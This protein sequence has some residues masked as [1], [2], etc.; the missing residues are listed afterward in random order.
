[1]PPSNQGLNM[2]L[3]PKDRLTPLTALRLVGRSATADFLMKNPLPKCP[4]REN[5]DKK[6]FHQGVVLP[7]PRKALLKI[8][9]RRG[10]RAGGEAEKGGGPRPHLHPTQPAARALPVLLREGEG[11][12]AGAQICLNPV[13]TGGGTT[14]P[15]DRLVL[16]PPRGAS[17]SQSANVSGL[18]SQRRN[19]R[20]VKTM[21][22]RRMPEGKPVGGRA[23]DVAS[24]RRR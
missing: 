19:R 10:A 7:S 4:T 11:G 5:E 21:N 22:G 8:T 3:K 20:G 17:L 9:R 1:M 18:P 13:Q 16:S 2:Y 6:P 15:G 12:S 23:P 24:R 14:L